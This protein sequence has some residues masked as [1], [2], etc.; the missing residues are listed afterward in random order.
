MTNCPFCMDLKRGFF[1]FEGKNLGSRVIGETDNFIVFPALGHMVEGY[2]LVVPKKH[3]GSMASL[4]EVLFPELEAVCKKTRNVL[5]RNYSPPVILE[6]G[7]VSE[8]QKAGQSVTHAHFHFVPVAADGLAENL[9]A[10]FARRRIDSYAQ[11]GEQFKKGES[12]FFVEHRRDRKQEKFIFEVPDGK[13]VQA[14]YLR[15]LA[16]EAAGKF[17]KWS[18]RSYP[19]IDELLKTRENLK[20]KFK[21]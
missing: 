18:W 8:G 21:F 19:G 2:L 10:H 11:L 15:Q 13:Y 14:E 12:Y 4:P 9:S 7:A 6:H 16:A 17:E 5:T 3:Y 1:E 20:G